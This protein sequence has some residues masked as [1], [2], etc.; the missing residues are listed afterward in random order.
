MAPRETRTRRTDRKAV[1]GREESLGGETNPRKEQRIQK[2][3]HTFGFDWTRRWRNTLKSAGRWCRA[4]STDGEGATGTA[5]EPQDPPFTR[6]AIEDRV[7]RPSSQEPQG[8]GPRERRSNGGRAIGVRGDSSHPSP[9]KAERERE[10]PGSKSWCGVIR[11]GESTPRGEQDQGAAAKESSRPAR[12]S[13]PERIDPQP[14][15]SAFRTRATG[16][17]RHRRPPR[18]KSSGPSA[19]CRR[20]AAGDG[21]GAEHTAHGLRSARNEA[22]PGR[23]S[24]RA[25]RGTAGGEQAAAMRYGCRRGAT[26]RRARRTGAP[27]ARSEVDPPQ[28]VEHQRPTQD[29]PGEPQIWC[30]LQTCWRPE[31]EDTVEVVE[32]TRTVRAG[33]WH[34]PAEAKDTRRPRKRERRRP[35]PDGTNPERPGRGARRRTRSSRRGRTR[36]RAIGGDVRQIRPEHRRRRNG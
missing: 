7:L 35:E 2:L 36:A 29:Q 33:R 34:R 1:T 24:D 14:N 3:Q 12:A 18:G 5:R 15:V 20:N 6:S 13:R 21:D 30:Q 11:Q 10:S 22:G 4:R 31:F 28:G 19:G 8:F 16:D 27:R 26:L 9:A 32:T 17:R 25:R 23:E